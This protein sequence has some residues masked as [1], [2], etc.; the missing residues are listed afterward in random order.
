MSFQEKGTWVFLIITAVVALVYFA[1]V[2]G[3]LGDTPASEINYVPLM[4]GA[5]IGNTIFLAGALASVATSIAKLVIYCRG[6]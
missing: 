6:F 2:I 5:V 4:I 3:Q 1:I